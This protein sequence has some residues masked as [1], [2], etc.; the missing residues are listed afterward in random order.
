MKITGD[1]RAL[2]EAGMA[3]KSKEFLAQGAQ[4]YTA[5]KPTEPVSAK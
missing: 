2:A 4:L 5:P 3:E 1:V